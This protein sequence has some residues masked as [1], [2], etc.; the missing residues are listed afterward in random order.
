MAAVRKFPATQLVLYR[1]PELLAADPAIP[2]YILEGEKDVDR[3]RALGMVGTCNPM[4]AG[5]WRKEYESHLQ[6]KPVILLPDN[7]QAGRDHAQ[8]IAINLNGVVASVKIV[9]LPDLP[10]KGDLSD[11]LDAGGTVDHLQALVDAASEFD[12]ATVP[13]PD[14]E[15]TIDKG[16][17]KGSGEEELSQQN[18][19]YCPW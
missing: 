17:K 3:L 8:K 16:T 12:P 11:W 7:D 4:G 14:A 10:E 19:R 1:L 13:A 9:E 18:G 5:K 2:V 6:G 15:T